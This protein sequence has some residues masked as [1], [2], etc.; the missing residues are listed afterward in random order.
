MNHRSDFTRAEL[1][2]IGVW[3]VLL[4]GVGLLVYVACYVATRSAL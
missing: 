2:A 4:A 3:T 1:R